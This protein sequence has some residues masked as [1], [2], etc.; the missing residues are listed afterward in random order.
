MAKV[1]KVENKDSCCRKKE[2]IKNLRKVH[3]QKKKNKKK[4][5]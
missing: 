5:S 1:D 3:I 2:L 4:Y